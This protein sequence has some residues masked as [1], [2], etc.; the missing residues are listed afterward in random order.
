MSA[1]RLFQERVKNAKNR[2][3]PE[4]R[5]SITDAEALWLAIDELQNRPPEV[6]VIEISKP[7][8]DNVNID[9]GRF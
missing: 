9:G 2:K 4:L 7:K 5:I 3:S 1:I 6:R 8:S